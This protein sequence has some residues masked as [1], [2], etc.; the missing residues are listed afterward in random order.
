MTTGGAVNQSADSQR[1]HRSFPFSVDEE[2]KSYAEV[3]KMR[4]YAA[5]TVRIYII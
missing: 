1:L 2:S 5:L 4:R 3:G